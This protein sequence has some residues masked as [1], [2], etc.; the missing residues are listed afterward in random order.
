MLRRAQVNERVGD[1]VVKKGLHPVV[2]IG[3]AERI[4]AG[5]VV[6]DSFFLRLGDLRPGEFVKQ[7]L[8]VAR[9]VGVAVDAQGAHRLVT[10]QR[11]AEIDFF[12]RGLGHGEFERPGEVFRQPR[13]I[14]RQ[15]VA[16][17]MYHQDFEHR[18]VVDRGGR[19]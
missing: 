12:E 5:V 15:V 16:D 14:A 18:R 9:L 8:A 10:V 4:L 3:P 7:Q 1:V 6:S 13:R 17:A 19:P 2:E 11:Y